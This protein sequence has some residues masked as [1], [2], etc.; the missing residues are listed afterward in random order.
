[1]RLYI[2]LI[3]LLIISVCYAQNF[4]ISGYVSDAQTGE[5]L[6]GATVYDAN[7]LIGTVTNNFGFYSFSTSTETVNLTI[8]YVGYAHHSVQLT[9]NKDT[10]IN[11][12]LSPSTS[13]QEVVV[14]ANQTNEIHTSQMGAI[15][16]PMKTA[17][18]L[19]VIFGEA[20]IVKTLQLMPGVQ[21]GSEA[22]SGMYVRGGG[23]DQNLVL[24]DGVPV[25][26]AN[27]LFGF[28]SVFNS[29]A[30][31]NVS[32]TKGAFP[33]RYGGRLSSVLDIS[34]KEGNNQKIGGTASIGLISSKFMLNGPISDKTS[35]LFSAR[36]TYADVLAIPYLNNVKQD[37]GYDEYKKGYYF[38]DINAKVNHKFNDR[39]RIYLSAYT[40]KDKY[41]DIC[42]KKW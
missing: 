13:L 37:K 34:M 16:L 11:I 24:L 12:N 5:K 29:D 40:G 8:S 21:S 9:L 30:I 26:N 42:K 15:N 32:L 2:I 14:E 41:S 36:R 19:P 7:R 27:H 10:L 25:Y 22:M 28:F 39:H 20:D 4:T 35:F 33:A 3:M 38:Y 31:Q 1:M 23:A 18:K 6:I 17:N